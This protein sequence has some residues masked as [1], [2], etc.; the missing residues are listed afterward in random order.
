[1]TRERVRLHEAVKYGDFLGP[2]VVDDFEP[3]S[4]EDHPEPTGLQL[5]DDSAVGLCLAATTGGN[6]LFEL[7]DTESEVDASPGDFPF[8]LGA[9]K[10][11]HFIDPWSTF[12]SCHGFKRGV[13]HT[14]AGFLLVCNLS[15]RILSGGGKIVNWHQ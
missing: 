4:L 3:A 7:V 11:V 15:K 14:L 9:L 6:V 13:T 1:M 12:R 5:S 2:M 8:F 10:V